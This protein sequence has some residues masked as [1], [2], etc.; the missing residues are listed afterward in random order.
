VPNA[1]TTKYW[2]GYWEVARSYAKELRMPKPGTKPA[3][4]NFVFFQPVG[5]R[6]DVRLV[7]KLPYGKVD[8]QFAGMGDRLDKLEEMYGTKLQAGM[9]IVKAAKSAAIRIAVPEIDLQAPLSHKQVKSG[10]DAAATLLR[11]YNEHIGKRAT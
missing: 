7:H 3:T 10:L 9:T 4:S 8:L 1:T 11:F 2:Q 5:L 6:A